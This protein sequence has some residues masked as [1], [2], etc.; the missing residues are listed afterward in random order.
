MRAKNMANVCASSQRQGRSATPALTMTPR[1]ASRY[2][3]PLFCV[4]TSHSASKHEFCGRMNSPIIA[5]STAP[6]EKNTDKAVT[7]DCLPS[8]MC[9][10]S[11][12]PS[13]GIEPCDRRQLHACGCVLVR[14]PTDDPRKKRTM[15]SWVKEPARE[16][17]MPKRAV[18]KSVALNAVL[19]PKRSE[20][21]RG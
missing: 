21:E 13:V 19:R 18:K 17:R 8:G 9:S 14:T 4:S 11:S 15:H 1:T 6:T 7:R 10:S 16:A 20:P 5:D 12:V 2:F 3:H